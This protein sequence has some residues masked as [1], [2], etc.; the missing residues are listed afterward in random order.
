MALSLAPDTMTADSTDRRTVVLVA[1]VAALVLQLPLVLN[2][3]YFSHDE[4]QWASAADR[5][6]TVDWLDYRAFQYRPLTFQLWLGL[7]RGLF[8]KPE[9]FHA[10]LA[11]LGA[12]NAAMLAHVVRCLGASSRLAVATALAFILNP[13]AMY[14]HGWVGTLGDLLWVGLGL[15]AGVI[16]LRA[17]A[18]TAMVAAA[19]A[20]SLALLAKE[21]ALSLP[22]LA[23]LLWLLDGSRRKAWRAAAAGA[24]IPAALYLAVRLPVLAAAPPD[25]AYAWT[26]GNVPLRWI[27][28]PLYLANAPV[29]EVHNTL[30][31]GLTKRVVAGALL[32]LALVFALLRADRRFAIAFVGGGALALGP[33]L[34][35]GQSATQYGY[36]FAAWSV[37]VVALSWP[38]LPRWGRAVAL[39]FAVLVALHAVNVAREMVRVGHVQAVFS[40]ALADVVARDADTVRLTPGPGAD[41]WIF[42]RLTHDVPSYRGVP[43]GPRVELLPAGTQ[44]DFRI[45]P[46]GRLEPTR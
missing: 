6:A 32:W 29:F 25:P 12:V 21:A 19:L 41:A 38:R 17:A 1:L 45:L 9:A 11:A 16:A 36:G 27:E 39:V 2:P 10:V 40:P 30:S 4:L 20:T 37:G 42:Q 24:G 13:Y 26:V 15:A 14:V 8:A 35:L 34:V 28:Y 44:A 43:L 46:D 5:G 7:S 22:A 31:Q 23:A 3:G 18:S 33:V